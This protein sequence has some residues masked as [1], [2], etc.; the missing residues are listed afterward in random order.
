MTDTPNTHPLNVAVSGV[1][2][3]KTPEEPVRFDPVAFEH[4]RPVRPHIEHVDRIQT[5]NVDAEMLASELRLA[6]RGEV[7]F[8][9]GARALYATD[10]SNYRQVPIG[11]VVP[12][13]TEDVIATVE[14]CRSHGV[15][16]VSRGGGTSLAG[17]TCNVAVVI[18]HSKFNNELL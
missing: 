3:P 14:V 5:V 8:D 7:R 12:R 15:P 2:S 9:D 4:D 13:D 10:A 16:I 11:V 1:S 6:I 17:Q 18:D